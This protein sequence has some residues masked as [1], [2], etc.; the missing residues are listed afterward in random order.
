MKMNL[1][2]RTFA[3][4]ISILLL[5]SC[6]Q[7]PKS[8][9]KDQTEVE[10]VKVGYLPMVS[11]LTHFVA[12]EKGFYKEQGL[13][14]E[15][16]EIKTSNLIAQELA[17]GHINIGVELALTPLLKQNEI[18]KNSIR[19]FSTSNITTEN[20]FDAILVK[21]DSKINSL[22][23]LSGKKIGGF[24]G[25]TAKVSLLNLFSK[26]YPKL[27]PPIFIELA[28]NLHIQSLENNEI[29]ALF[30][31]EPVLSTG[32]VKFEFRKI[33]PSVY[34]SQFTPNPIGVAGVN[35]SWYNSNIENATKYFIA[36]DK[37]IDFINSNPDE[38]R[39]ILA[40]ATNIEID[41]A[42]N[43]NILPLSKSKEIDMVNLDKYITILINLKEISLPVKAADICIKQQ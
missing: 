39:I 10:N 43:M 38:S 23:K 21:S 12:V 28:P 20:G 35:A 41:I 36:I 42:K 19:I 13:N 15:A 9:T 27:S 5:T 40:K 18:S 4:L 8:T 31:Y 6:N 1:K 30:A 7:N 25:S 32:I 14:V 17:A 11:S 34:G 3:I 22:D 37:A 26:L 24:P 2:F 29:D 33:F 16:A